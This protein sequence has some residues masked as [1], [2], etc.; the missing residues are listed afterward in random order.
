MKTTYAQTKLSLGLYFRKAKPE[1][2]MA[3]R[4]ET[5][6]LS[7]LSYAMVL[8]GGASRA[9]HNVNWLALASQPAVDLGTLLG[10]SGSLGARCLGLGTMA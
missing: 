7:S 9:K 8:A 4:P 10:L 3:K 1:T 5:A 2:V 6:D